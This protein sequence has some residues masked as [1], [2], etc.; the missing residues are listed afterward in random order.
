MGIEGE[1]LILNTHKRPLQT[2][3]AWSVA[4]LPL[5]IL[6]TPLPVALPMATPARP[7][8]ILTGRRCAVLHA[9]GV[10]TIGPTTDAE[11]QSAM[12]DGGAM[13]PELTCDAWEAVARA[14]LAAEGDGVEAW[15]RLSLVSRAWRDGLK[16][17]RC[18]CQETAVVRREFC[19]HE[20]AQSE[21]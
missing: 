13:G 4:L 12:A 2:D 5:L 6:A 7:A 19:V 17:A 20:A 8:C 11:P 3:V 16:G 1:N 21:S 15:T 14:A 9:H 10:A 18:S